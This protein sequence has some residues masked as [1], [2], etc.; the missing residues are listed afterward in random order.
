MSEDVVAAVEVAHYL[1]LSLQRV[2]QL[3]AAGTLPARAL[4]DRQYVVDRDVLEEFAALRRLPHT[5]AF[6]QP[7]AWAAAAFADGFWEVPW[8]NPSERSRLR[9]RLTRAA[10][11]ER[12][13]DRVPLWRMRL[14]RL[15]SES[16]RLRIHPARLGELLEDPRI[17]A[18]GSFAHNLIGDG[19]RG[20]A[21]TVWMRN[22]VSVDE[23]VYDYALLPS[24]RANLTIRWQDGDYPLA[25]DRQDRSPWRLVVVADLVAE[26]DTRTERAAYNLL[27]A[28]L[29]EPRWHSKGQR[30]PSQLGQTRN[31]TTEGL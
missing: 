16:I 11:T 17:L 20:D 18:S 8:L 27:A 12:Q 10:S 14:T 13:D 24:P 3:I 7:V 6:S 28:V 2:H 23:L 25:S 9:A 26:Q 4:T 22:G 15:A 31:E 1:G 19:L 5:R 29:E 30:V 21:G